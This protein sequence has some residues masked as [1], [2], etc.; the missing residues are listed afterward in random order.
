LNRWIGAVES[1]A[2]DP[3]A[4]STLEVATFEDDERKVRASLRFD[5]SDAKK[6]EKTIYGELELRAE[7]DNLDRERVLMIFTRSDVGD[8]A[9]GQRSGERVVIDEISQKPL[10]ITYGSSLTEERIKHE[11]RESDENIYKKGFS[12]DVRVQSRGGTPVAYSIMHVHDV[13]DLPD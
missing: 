9:V 3:N 5:T 6:I 11:I 8:A 1:I 4:S 2:R 7:K 13:I 12:V 10:A